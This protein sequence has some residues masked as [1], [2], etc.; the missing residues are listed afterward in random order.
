MT[1]AQ[2]GKNLRDAL[3]AAIQRSGRLDPLLKERERRKRSRTRY[4]AKRTEARRR[5]MRGGVG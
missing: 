2:A 1:R 5:S 4:R 3:I